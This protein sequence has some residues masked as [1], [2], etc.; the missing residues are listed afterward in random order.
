MLSNLV[1]DSIYRNQH[2]PHCTPL[3]IENIELCCTARPAAV[4]V[5]DP[6]LP[7]WLNFNPAWIINHMFS[8]MWEEI[9]YPFPQ[10]S[11]LAP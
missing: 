2:R 1:V 4:I 6:L 5:L 3:H 9:T 11:M 8:E 7:T 10:T